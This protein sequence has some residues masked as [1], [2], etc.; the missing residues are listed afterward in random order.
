MPARDQAAYMREWR[1]RQKERTPDQVKR[2]KR[3]RRNIK[4][5]RTWYAN[6]KEALKL[7]AALQLKTLAEA[8][9]LLERNDKC[10]T[11][12]CSAPSQTA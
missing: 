11:Q 1:K 6:N 10:K 3:Y 9:A 8:R 5:I 4:T 12:T 2:R 7:K